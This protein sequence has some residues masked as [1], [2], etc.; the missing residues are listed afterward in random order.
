VTARSG[1]PIRNLEICGGWT[2][3]ESPS[4]WPCK[5]PRHA[6]PPDSLTASPRD[7]H[8]GAPAAGSTYLYSARAEDAP[9]T[10]AAWCF[11][12]TLSAHFNNARP[13][14][15]SDPPTEWRSWNPG[16][17]QSRQSGY[18]RSSC[19][20]YGSSSRGYKWIILLDPMMAGHR[21]ACPY[22]VGCA[23][24]LSN[25]AVGKK[26][27]ITRAT[28]CKWRGRFQVGR[29]GGLL[30]E[31]RLGASTFIHRILHTSWECAARANVKF[32][33][34]LLFCV[35]YLG[36]QTATLRGVVTDQ[37]GAVIPKAQVSVKGSS[38]LARTVAAGEDGAYL[39]T[40]L[41]PRSAAS[42]RARLRSSSTTPS[43][44]KWA[45]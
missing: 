36:A 23:E 39:F 15:R 11:H 32:I 10:A 28:V 4:P 37:T 35:G 25:G 7:H 40:N 17:G 27:H 12:A 14:D 29:L 24:G 26:L 8:P 34:A 5:G 3:S 22:C 41:P 45:I 42:G 21:D 20:L 19:W 18:C 13:L 16:F 33:F 38:G 30:D 44:A 6:P 9:A 31:S 1:S 43:E 2:R